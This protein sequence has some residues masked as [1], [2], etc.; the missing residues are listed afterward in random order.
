MR[1]NGS[2]WPVSVTTWLIDIPR[3]ECKELLEPAPLG[4]LRL[5]LDGRPEI[6]PVNH[7]YDQA[8]GCVAFRTNAESELHRALDWPWVAYEVD[9]VEADGK[10]GWGVSVIGRAEEITEAAEI[11]RLAGERRVLWRSGTPRSVRIVPTKVTGRR[12]SATAR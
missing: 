4:R 5:V 11:A 2:G 9:G 3:Q 6:F 7:V 10:G 1:A 8:A 12:I